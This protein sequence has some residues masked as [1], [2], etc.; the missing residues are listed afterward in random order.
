MY[1][2]RKRHE[3]A[4]NAAPGAKGVL[5][6][7]EETLK[8]IVWENDEVS[9]GSEKHCWIHQYGNED[10]YHSFNLKK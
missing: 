10:E 8:S 4:R 6:R 5:G 1:V 3:K 7:R 9:A 2:G